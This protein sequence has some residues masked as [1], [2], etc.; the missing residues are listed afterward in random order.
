MP[1]PSHS[2][3]FD[4]PKNIRKDAKSGKSEQVDNFD[5]DDEDLSSIGF[6]SIC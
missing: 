2:S 5:N 4:H 1:H 3:W 6:C